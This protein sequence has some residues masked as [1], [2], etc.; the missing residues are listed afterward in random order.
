VREEVTVLLERMG[1]V[2]GFQ[3]LKESCDGTLKKMAENLARKQ[4][5]NKK[6]S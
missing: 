4:R 2:I 6:V 1:R 5:R 3:K